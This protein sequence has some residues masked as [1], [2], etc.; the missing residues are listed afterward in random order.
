MEDPSA[1]EPIEPLIEETVLTYTN[2]H[3]EVYN[4]VHDPSQISLFCTLVFRGKL[5][6]DEVILVSLA[7]RKKYDE[8]LP[9]PSSNTT[10]LQRKL[11]KDPSSIVQLVQEY[12]MS[13]G[14]HVHIVKD[15]KVRLEDNRSLVVYCS[16]N[17]RST[18]KA[19]I[20]ANNQFVDTIY[21]KSEGL[22]NP[23]ELNRLKFLDSIY[24]TEVHHNA[25]RHLI[26]DVDLDSKI[27]M[28]YLQSVYERMGP[29]KVV[30]LVET[31][32]G[33][34]MLLNAEKVDQKDRAWLYKERPADLVKNDK[35]SILKDMACPLPGTFQ[36]GFPV[37]LVDL[38]TLS[39]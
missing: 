7:S 32:G 19:W 13:I 18:V 9:G 5:K 33:Y 25:S 29:D 20:S 17:P 10:Y 37:R 2:K 22:A 34:H 14:S 24:K 12:E 16:C 4:L 11:V 3:V 15:Q 35:V 30:C 27:H 36:G 26:L 1:N 23:D 38:A 6:D 21:K 31:R 8:S 39:E 28:G